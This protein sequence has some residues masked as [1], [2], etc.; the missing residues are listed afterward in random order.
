MRRSRHDVASV[1]PMPSEPAA[2]VPA[3]AT[4]S[5]AQRGSTGQLIRLAIAV[6]VVVL[7]WLL[8]TPR[9]GGPDEPSHTVRAAALVRGQL[10]GE[11]SG[12]VNSRM[13]ELPGHVGFPDPVCYAFQPYVSAACIADAQ[14]PSGD[15]LAG[16]RAATYPVWGHLLPGIGTLF[17]SA[18]APWMARVFDAVLPVLLIATSLSVAA[19]RGALGAAVTLLSVT[20]MAWFLFGVVNPSGLV[21]AGGIGLWSALVALP[22]TGTGNG[23]F[24]SDR[25]VRCLLASSWAALIL[26]RRDGLIWAVFVL[27]IAM[28][29]LQLTPRAVWAALGNGSRAVVCLSTMAVLGWAATSSTNDARAL[30]LAPL[31]PV[32]AV[33][34]RS[35]WRRLTGNVSAQ[36]LV[37]G[38]GL[39]LGAVVM[40]LVMSTRNSGFDRYVLRLVIGYTGD[41][42]RGA[43]GILGWLD[44]PIPTASLYLFVLAIGALFGFAFVDGQRS[45]A[46]SM[47]AVVG[48]AVT[49]SWTLT[50]LQNNDTGTYWQGRYY[51][52]LLVGV[53]ILGSRLRID[54]IRSSRLAALLVTVAA[55][56][57]NVGL[58]AMMRRFSGGIAGTL[59]P[60]EWD[61]YGAPLAPVALLVVHM[62]AWLWLVTWCRNL[63][64]A[65]DSPNESRGH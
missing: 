33:A 44:T 7:T 20:P 32:A 48:V 61:T 39:L 60:W 49:A 65:T 1:V 13:F 2:T 34:A 55:I 10:D 57:T 28:L 35:T 22:A 18:L 25:L 27:S 24:A 23:K 45:L 9:S 51:L 5:Q 6:A 64:Q 62:M 11:A 26:P 36:R 63:D 52:P 31:I 21:V 40:V 37:V 38:C 59:L 54:G 30:F 14:A 58:A 8:A 4:Q 53:P 50:M 41:N 15:V 17:P 12:G 19:R 56:V 46:V 43:V 42:L 3:P 29:G 16:T 47:A